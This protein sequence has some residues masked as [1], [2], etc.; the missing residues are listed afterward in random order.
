MEQRKGDVGTKK[1]RQIAVAEEFI[2]LIEK[3][4]MTQ[5][6]ENP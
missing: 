3:Y 6:E 1:E 2:S 5:T 4:C